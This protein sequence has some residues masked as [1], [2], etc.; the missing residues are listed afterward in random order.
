MSQKRRLTNAV[1]VLG[2]QSTALVAHGRVPLL[3]LLEVQV[4]VLVDNLLAVLPL[5]GQVPILAVLD[6]ACLCGSRGVA[7]RLRVRVAGGRARLHTLD[8]HAVVK[9]GPET[10]AFLVDLGVPLH[11]LLHADAVLGAELVADVALL[12]VVEAVAVLGR[13]VGG[14]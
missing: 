6:D 4:A 1:G 3:E 5:L 10:V 14:W 11:E 13:A 2:P 7:G 8:R 12:D 9:V